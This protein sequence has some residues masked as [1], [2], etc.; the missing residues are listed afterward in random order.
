MIEYAEVE[1]LDYNFSIGENLEVS[2]DDSK[3]TIF[4]KKPFL[5]LMQSVLFWMLICLKQKLSF[6]NN[7]LG[8]GSSINDVTALGGEGV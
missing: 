5:P 2:N 3:Q 8:K 1:V 6:K 7:V 4:P